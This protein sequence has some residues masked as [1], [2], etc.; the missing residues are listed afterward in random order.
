MGC[1][2]E[3]MRLLQNRVEYRREIAGRGIDDLQHLGG[4]GLLLQRLARLGDEPRIL[5][6]DD[7]LRREILQQHD[8]LA[9]EWPDLASGCGDGAKERVVFAERHDEQGADAGLDVR[10]RYGMVD[11]R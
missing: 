6:G 2:T 8:F 11:L 1:A 7:R 3:G 9:R 4:R 10:V 5:C